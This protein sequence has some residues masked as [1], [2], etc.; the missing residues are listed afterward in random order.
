MDGGTEGVRRHWQLRRGEVEARV[1]VGG[2]AVVRMGIDVRAV[3][4][5][6]R[7]RGLESSVTLVVGHGLEAECGR[8]REAADWTR[9]RGR[10][11]S[12]Q[13]EHGAT[14]AASIRWR[15]PAYGGGRAALAASWAEK[16]Y[17]ACEAR[18]CCREG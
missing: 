9:R 18:R 10:R 8:W 16:R 1:L 17:A 6:S 14:S 12:Q 4:P 11:A 3:A 13:T 5:V 7:R 2:S 15:L